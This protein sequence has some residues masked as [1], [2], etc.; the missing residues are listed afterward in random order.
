MSN[1]VTKKMLRNMVQHLNDALG[2]PAKAFVRV[3]ERTV[4]QVGHLE[5]EVMSPGDG[6]TRYT[7]HE[8]QNEGGGVA[9]RSLCCTA[10]EMY[11]VLDTLKRAL[12]WGEFPNLKRSANWL[13]CRC[14]SGHECADLAERKRTRQG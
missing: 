14:G 10:Q 9:T 6:W 8:I 7:L 12:L 11:A 4:G 5:L 3:G 2:R 13:D 1:R